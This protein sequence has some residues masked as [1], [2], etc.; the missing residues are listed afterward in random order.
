MSP[1]PGAV[2]VGAPP[3]ATLAWRLGTSRSCFTALDPQNKC[4]HI[5]IYI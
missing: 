4:I 1:Q 3:L 5:Y 2:L